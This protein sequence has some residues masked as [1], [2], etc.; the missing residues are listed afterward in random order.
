MRKPQAGSMG[1]LATLADLQEILQEAGWC[2]RRFFFHSS[3]ILLWVFSPKPTSFDPGEDHLVKGRSGWGHHS[4][5]NA[6]QW[7]AETQ[8]GSKRPRSVSNRTCVGENIAGG[9][10]VSFF[11]LRDLMRVVLNTRY[12]HHPRMLAA[13]KASSQ[14][15]KPYICLPATKGVYSRIVG[16]S[17][18]CR[19]ARCVL[20]V[21]M[22]R[23]CL[24]RVTGPA[25]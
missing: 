10:W 12:K 1:F 6:R 13:N 14:E 19:Q 8:A 17:K 5:A 15:L 7:G 11:L 18:I 16:V 23:L 4:R 9:R 3:P 2:E 21:P 22:A 25:P 24:G 20:K